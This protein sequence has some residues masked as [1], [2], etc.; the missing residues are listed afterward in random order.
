[1][2]PRDLKTSRS[3]YGSL[4]RIPTPSET[5]CNHWYAETSSVVQP[6]YTWG[7][8]PPAISRKV[9]K[10]WCLWVDFCAKYLD[11]MSYK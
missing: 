1:M 5:C 6:G 9:F 3:A 4:L 2:R 8:P 7:T 11:S 10:I